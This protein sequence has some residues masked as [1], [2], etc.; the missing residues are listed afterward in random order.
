MRTPA[1]YVEAIRAYQQEAPND[2]KRH[3]AIADDGTFTTD[4]AAFVGRKA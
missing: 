2:V 3:F 4:I 1:V